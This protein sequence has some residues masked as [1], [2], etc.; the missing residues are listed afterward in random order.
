MIVKQVPDDRRTDESSYILYEYSDE[1]DDAFHG[2]RYDHNEY[3]KCER[4]AEVLNETSDL[5]NPEHPVMKV[6][7]GSI[8]FRHVDFAYKKDSDE[9]VLEDI[10]LKIRSGETIGIIGGTGS[11]KTSLVNLISRLYDVTK[12]EVLVGGKNVKDYDMEVLRNQ[13]SV[14]LQN[15]VLFSGTILD[16][17]RW[18]DKEATRKNAD[19]RVNLHVRMNS[20]TVSRKDMRPISSRAEATYPEVRNRDFVSQEHYLRSP[21]Y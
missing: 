19:M 16:N 13:V 6:E 10:D 2:I 4:I 1:P 9:P 5:K 15:N 21:K 18:G 7:D 3:G 14:V 8:E 11:A 12:G 20:S 17:L